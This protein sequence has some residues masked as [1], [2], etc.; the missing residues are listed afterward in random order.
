MPVLDGDRE[1]E[2][3]QQYQRQARRKHSKRGRN[4]DEQ[5]NTFK[6]WIHCF[7]VWMW[8]V[9]PTKMYEMSKA[10]W[11]RSNH[12]RNVWIAKVTSLA[13]R[14]KTALHRR[15]LL[16][17][18]LVSLK[19][20]RKKGKEKRSRVNEKEVRTE[21]EKEVRDTRLYQRKGDLEARAIGIPT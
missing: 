14:K 1:A 6:W 9:S 10:R 15:N 18:S 12:D 2:A 21:Q 20:I 11:Q 17:N 13:C 16:I 7:N 3:M 19:K 5:W 4:I 8:Q